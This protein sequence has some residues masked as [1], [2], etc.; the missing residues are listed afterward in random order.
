MNTSTVMYGV[1]SLRE[2]IKRL[3]VAEMVDI[4]AMNGYRRQ[5]CRACTIKVRARE[6]G[7]SQ[8]TEDRR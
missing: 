6:R 8:D 3:G 7:M 4:S 2:R 5:S 1:P